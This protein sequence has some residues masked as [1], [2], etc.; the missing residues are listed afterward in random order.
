M[1]DDAIRFSATVFKIQTLVDGGMR[2]T[3]D[4]EPTPET[5][6]AL[7]ESKQPGIILEVAA[8]PIVVQS[9]TNGKTKTDKRTARNPLDVAGG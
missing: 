4:I 5:I 8:V 6:L 3:L 7:F 2:L 9:L 1:S